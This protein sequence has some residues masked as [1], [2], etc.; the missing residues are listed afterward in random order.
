M[1]RPNTGSG[2]TPR[3]GSWK[4]G[5]TK[6]LNE[7]YGFNRPDTSNRFTEVPWKKKYKTV[8]ESFEATLKL[9]LEGTNVIEQQTIEEYYRNLQE[10]K[11]NPYIKVS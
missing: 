8:D 1:G 5:H 2:F 6:N 7:Y 10:K 9:L 4:E 11:G 3:P